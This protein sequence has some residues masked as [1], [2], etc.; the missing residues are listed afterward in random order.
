MDSQIKKRSMRVLVGAVAATLPICS[1]A[2]TVTEQRI[3]QLEQA[4][5]QMQQQRAEQDKQI[6]LLTKELVAIEN[7]VTQSKTTRTEERGK[8]EGKPVF[9][10]FKDGLMF[11]D[12]SGDWKL[13]MN[14]RVQADF[15]TY[16]PSEWKDDNFAI[17][18]A[19]FGGTF[20]FL[21]DFAVR[22]EGE[23]ANTTGSST[24]AMTYGYLDFSR[25]KEA[26]IR[27]GQF[28]PFFGLERSYS[29]NFLDFTELSLATNNGS[30]FTS[31][32]DRGVMLF[33]DPLPWLNYNLYTVNGTGQ[34]SDDQN[35]GKDIGGRV[36]ANL[37]SLAGIK[38]AVIHVGASASKGDLG[39]TAATQATEGMGTTFFNVTG[40]A[41][42]SDRER[43]GLETAVSYGP[44]KLQ[45]EYIDAN[46]EGMRGATAYDNDIKAWYADINWLITGETW[47]DAYKSGVFG[48]I[49]PKQNFDTKD[50][51]GA[52]ELGLRY[53]KFDGSDFQ[54]MIASTTAN[55]SE[56]AAWT[57]GAKWIMNPNARVL[58]NYIQT[59]FD[60]PTELTINGKTDDKE[61]AVILRAQYDF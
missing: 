36:N 21:K 58:L 7:Q 45:A 9:A 38:N 47:A 59:E 15:R 19:R 23:Y 44:V 6:D 10:A 13:Q 48:R 51:W 37:A 11:E 35:D 61:R 52:F 25:W 49:R 33:G 27:A 5:Q 40:L 2:E 14:G 1:Y 53:S 29:T 43:W 31:T 12:G 17:R 4:V 34:N 16:D 50:G 57:V 46:F 41:S 8:S 32:Y 26:K 56:A 60:Q 39:K 30:I 18:R 20:T 28:K 54:S 3:K 22:V 55:A 24:T 42:N